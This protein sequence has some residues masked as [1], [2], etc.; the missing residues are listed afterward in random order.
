[1]EFL[2]GGRLGRLGYF[3]YSLG[4]S[5]FIG[6]VMVAA[7]GLIVPH[8][9]AGKVTPGGAAAA[10][11]LFGGVFLLTA[12]VGLILTVKRL[13]D[14]GLSGWYYLLILVVQTALYAAVFTIDSR[15]LR[16]MALGTQLLIWFMICF[17]PGTPGANQYGER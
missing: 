1:M 11:L 13:H 6:L 10:I 7:T 16:M 15:D 17:W 8:D 9:P 4:Y 5:I 12:F 2:F 3:G 14:L